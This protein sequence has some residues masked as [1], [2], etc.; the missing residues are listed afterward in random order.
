MSEGRH[1]VKQ[2][3]KRQKFPL[4]KDSTVD[5]KDLQILNVLQNQAR[6]TNQDLS[7][8]VNLSPSATLHRVRR[9]ET[10]GLV[11]GY[12][13][14]I[15]IERLQ[16]TLM[17]F[18][19]VTLTSHRSEDFN[20]FE[21]LIADIPEIIC[22]YQI[23]GPFDYLLQAMCQDID[24]WRDLADRLLSSNQGIAKITSNIKMKTAKS[25][26]G[27]QLKAQ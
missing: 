1:K 17:V 13:A 7:A 4:A 16:P 15:D 5:Q 24:S 25:F 2:N 11:R 9:L 8:K 23:S 10:I 27:Y 26:Q 20:S 22:A 6:I 3:Y 18:A 21:G 14:E 12:W 19:E